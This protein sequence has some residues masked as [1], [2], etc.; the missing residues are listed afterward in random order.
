ME[1]FGYRCAIFSG[2]S[3]EPEKA[4]EIIKEEIIKLHETGIS[5][6]DFEIAKRWIYG[7]TAYSLDSNYSIA[8]E[9]ISAEFTG[10]GIFE[11]ADIMADITLDDV[12]ERLKEQLDPNN[13][14][15][16]VIKGL[17]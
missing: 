4:A 8:S 7:G 10:R 15:L 16:S 3:R 2:E 12:N 17:D 1:G 5:Q 11:D 13:C 14:S 9:V 6:E